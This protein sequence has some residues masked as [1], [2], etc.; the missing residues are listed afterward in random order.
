MSDSYTDVFGG[1]PVQPGDVSYNAIALAADTTLVW[2]IANQDT[3]NVVAR[4]NDVTPSAGSLSITMPDATQV[5]PGQDALFANLGAN[6]FT[7]KASDGTEIATVASSAVI[8]LY[9][10][11]NATAAGSWRVTTFASTT[12]S[13]NA[14]ALAGQ[15][16]TA[17]AGTLNQESDVTTFAA[18]TTAGVGDR[19]NTLVS[20]GG[21]ITLSFTAAATLG[22]GW[23]VNVRNSGSGALTLDP[24]GA[25]TIDG[26]STK[27]LNAGESCTVICSG[28]A[29]YTV[30]YGRTLTSSFTRLVKSV[31][32]NTD[33]TL[34]AT[35]AANQ[36]QEY[37]G[38]LTGNINVI[39]PTSVAEYWVYNNT[40]GAFTLTAKTSAGTGIAVTQGTRAILYCD[41]TN[42]VTAQDTTAGTVTSVATGT[43]LTGGPITAT[44]TISLANTAVAAGN[45]GSASAVPVLTV[46]AQGRI[47]AASTAALGTAAVKDTGT[48]G[49]KVPLL[50]GANTWSAD[51]TVSGALSD[52]KGDVR[53]IPQNAQAA[54]YTLVASDAGKH[55]YASGNVTVP[56]AVFSVGDAVTVM[57]STTGN[58]SIVQGASTTLRQAGTANT[59]NRTLAQFGV[60][61]I[62]CFAANSFVISGAGL[63]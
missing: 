44:G 21:A 3:A 19:G 14:A 39:V 5:S 43:G 10:T 61:T 42:V 11:D 30:G 33:V 54:P 12:T 16:L 50:D 34:T 26:A 8:Y 32:G 56:T 9:L 58:I 41:A 63:S 15:G 62:L 6:T 38:A 46:D 4:I 40:S 29:L 17:I 60:C 35:E 59:G 24:S 27:T 18:D 49:N 1:S 28:T 2:P 45:Y 25:E 53:D 23:F 48:S 57:N 7:L 36:I 31:A 13:A 47:T 37:T 51:Q 22:N 52:S 55:I 20:T